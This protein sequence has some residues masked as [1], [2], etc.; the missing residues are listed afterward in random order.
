[1]ANLERRIGNFLGLE[2]KGRE[3]RGERSG[4]LSE[5]NRKRGVVA[6]FGLAG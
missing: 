4:K 3:L 6:W 2:K 1:M 5:V